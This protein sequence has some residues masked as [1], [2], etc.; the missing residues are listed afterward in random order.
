MPCPCCLGR[1]A[2]PP[3]FV[4]V[5]LGDRYCHQCE[6][7]FAVELLQGQDPLTDLG[8]VLTCPT[9]GPATQWV[10]PRSSG[11]T[12]RLNVGGEAQG[13]G[14][15]LLGSIRPLHRS[16]ASGLGSIPS[17]GSLWAQ[18][19]PPVRFPT[20]QTET[21][22]SALPSSARA[23]NRAAMPGFFEKRPP[24]RPAYLCRMG[25][26]AGWQDWR[27]PGCRRR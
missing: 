27:C 8:D 2:T 9:H 22:P 3:P 12:G 4:H 23:T 5:R 21:L 14:P 24:L 11:G 6:W 20:I 16:R 25:E 17:G 13:L 19:F 7:V 10:I 15:R 18:R 1:L 26:R